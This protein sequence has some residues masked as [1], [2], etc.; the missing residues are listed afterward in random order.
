MSGYQPLFQAAD[1]FIRLANDLAKDDPSGNIGAALRFA[2]A[3]YSAFEASQ[4]T[5]D[6]AG[7]K[8]KLTETIAED[9]RRML[10]HNVDDY[11][12][13]LASKA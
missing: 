6:L 12:R 2:A 13:H 5:A 1:Q 3:R 11:I 7:D 4:T 10:G 8:A 9:F